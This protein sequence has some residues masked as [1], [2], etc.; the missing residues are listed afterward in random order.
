MFENCQK[1]LVV[2]FQL[3]SI[4]KKK[5]LVIEVHL[6]FI[7]NKQLVVE[8]Q[9]TSICK[10]KWLVIEVHLTFIFNMQDSHSKSKTKQNIL[11]YT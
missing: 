3:T 11:E 6:T 5:R 10:K 1:Q 7:F 2:E 4:C 8:F 9:L